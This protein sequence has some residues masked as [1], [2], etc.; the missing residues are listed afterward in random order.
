MPKVGDVITTSSGE[1]FIMVDK[2]VSDGTPATTATLATLLNQVNIN[3]NILIDT[4]RWAGNYDLIEDTLQPHSERKV[5]Q[6]KFPVRYFKIYT[7][8]P[9]KLQLND[10]G[11]KS[12]GIDTTEMPFVLD[13]ITPG[14]YLWRVYVTPGSLTTNLK[15]LVMG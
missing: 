1:S 15:I 5:Y 3:L 6:F 12:I 13:N 8:Q 11:N 7:N 2:S 10:S 4:F 14:F 9:I